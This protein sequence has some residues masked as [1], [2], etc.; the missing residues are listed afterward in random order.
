M[1]KSMAGTQRGVDLSDPDRLL[2]AARG[3]EGETL[4]ELAAGYLRALRDCEHDVRCWSDLERDMHGT[5]AHRWRATGFMMGVRDGLARAYGLSGKKRHQTPSELLRWA[6]SVCGDALTQR[7]CPDSVA[8]R[9]VCRILEERV[10]RQSG[11][12]VRRASRVFAGAIAGAL[13]AVAIFIGRDFAPPKSEHLLA[14]NQQA[15]DIVT[16]V[17]EERRFEKDSFLNVSD[18]DRT[19]AYL[20]RWLSTKAQLD[21]AIVHAHALATEENDLRALAAIEDDL[22]RYADGYRQVSAQMQ[23]GEILSAEEANRRLT[24][25]KAAAHDAEALGAALRASTARRLL[26]GMG[27]SRAWPQAPTV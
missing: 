8:Y 3:A 9:V 21:R 14:L 27:I 1:E 18:R 4:S 5:D 11:V 2:S 7:A 16:L 20:S 24:I 23:A 12:Q 15:A 17:L 22:R 13:V 26:T 10:D 19:A 25:Y 6:T